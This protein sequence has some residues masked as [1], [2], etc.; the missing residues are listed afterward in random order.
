MIRWILLG[1][2][3]AAI[4]IVVIIS[5]GPVNADDRGIITKVLKGT[6]PDVHVDKMNIAEGWALAELG[7]KEW[8]GNALLRVLDGKWQIATMGGGVLDVVTISALGAPKH[9]WKKLLL[10]E[11]PE[12]AFRE[13]ANQGPYW[14]WLTSE[15][16]VTNDELRGKSAWELTL[17][18]NEIYA[19]H[20]RSFKDSELRAYFKSRAW[21]REDPGFSD[22]RLTEREKR[23]ASFIMKYQQEHNLLK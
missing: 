13:A 9:L 23:N 19:R 14:S 21:Y 5:A 2:T 7:G 20:G 3:F 22:A 17:M 1:I 10:Y 4:S 11:P 6:G 15:R 18:R 8:E 16:V 12:S